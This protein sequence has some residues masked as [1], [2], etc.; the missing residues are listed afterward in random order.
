MTCIVGYIDKQNKEV[1]MGGDSAGVGGLDIRSRK[2]VKVFYKDNMLIGY[3]SSFRMGQLL[4]FKLKI[5]I[6]KK[7]KDVYE[8]MCSDF[9]DAVR[10]CLIK[11]GY[12]KK[13]DNVEEIGVFLVAF[14][15]RLFKIE[16]DLQVEELNYPYNACGCG[17]PYAL[18]SIRTLDYFTDKESN[19]EKFINIALQ[20]AQEFSAGVRQPFTI[21]KLK[22]E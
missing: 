8:Y 2:D 7:G 21:L 5:P 22:G 10:K 3:T 20:T 13:A 11:N 15:G 1:W 4:R 17:E 16:D 14:K 19:G 12:G 9:I 18:A 6:L